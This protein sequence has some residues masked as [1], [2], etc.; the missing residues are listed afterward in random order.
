MREL[1]EDI[2]LMAESLDVSVHTI[3]K[4]QYINCRR[5]GRIGLTTHY[6][7]HKII[8]DVANSSRLHGS[9]NLRPQKPKRGACLYCRARENDGGGDLLVLEVLE[10]AAA[11]LGHSPNEHFPVKQG[12]ERDFCIRR[13]RHSVDP[14]G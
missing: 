4:V 11:Q 9:I 6:Q 14:S 2:V 8:V 1:A 12:F 3:D 5:Q 13:D 10:R 7:P